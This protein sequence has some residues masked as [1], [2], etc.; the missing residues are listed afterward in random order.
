MSV[1]VVDASAVVDLLT[2]TS[3]SDAISEALSAAAE[4]HAPHIID[5]EVTQFLR[6]GS[7]RTM[8]P[9]EFERLEAELVGLG[10]IRHPHLPFLP[11]I[12]E[13]RHSLTA[14]DASYVALAELLDAPL[15]TRDAKLARARGHTARVELI[16]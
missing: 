1:V 2:Q 16:D 14:Y 6:K 12:W 10:I 4:I 13:L 9:T 15:L 5:L 8:A 7:G 11:R 3:F